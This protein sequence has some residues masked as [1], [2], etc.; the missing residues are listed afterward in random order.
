VNEHPGPESAAPRPTA[1]IAEGAQTAAPAAPADRFA[2]GPPE[3]PWSRLATVSTGVVVALAVWAALLSGEKAPSPD[4]PSV[5][6][7]QKRLEGDEVGLVVSA[8]T[9][10]VPAL[11]GIVVWILVASRR[12][13][14]RRGL[15]PA[16]PPAAPPPRLL[17]L[18]GAMLVFVAYLV[19]QVGLAMVAA[20]LERQGLFA[21]GTL[22]RLEVHLAIAAA[23]GLPF[24]LWVAW[25]R[26]RSGPARPGWAKAALQVFLV[27]SAV[28][29]AL[30]LVAVVVQERLTGAPPAPQDLVTEA[31]RSADAAFWTL[32]VFG[33]TVAPFV[34]E[35]MFRGLLYPAARGW[36]GSLG[37][38]LGVS[39][40]FAAVHG[41]AFAYLPL[42]GFALLLAG[43]YEAT[44][45]LR[46]VTLAHSLYNLSSFVPL[47]YLRSV[48]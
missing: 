29:L 48:A 22:K 2:A 26:A 38:T 36:V 37:A 46:A 18:G 39:I 16:P 13:A 7:L 4:A 20:E 23:S 32:A 14:I 41:S 34:E 24:G 1:E 12:R 28:T 35:A 45:S 11:A 47:F 6:D 15:L 5:A 27:G 3:W 30:Y 33:V 21:A 40:L 10:Y 9:K 8:A 43:L 42:F 31:V 19:A 17:P 25:R 44:S